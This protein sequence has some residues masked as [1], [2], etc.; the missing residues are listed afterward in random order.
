MPSAAQVDPA[1]AAIITNAQ[2]ASA[3][4]SNDFPT[5]VT[6]SFNAGQTIYVTFHLTTN[7]QSGYVEAKFYVD[8]TYAK[9]NILTVKPSY[10][11]GYF[12]VPYNQAATGT[13]GL[14][15]C[16]QSNCSD[17]KLATFVTFTV[18]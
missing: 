10:D 8:S 3:I 12:G 13:V 11:H 4:D 5:T 18:A 2:T 7:G 14:Y 17:A 9:N 6:S 15:W 1:A 16:A